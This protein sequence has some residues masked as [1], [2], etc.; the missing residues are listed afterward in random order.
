MESQLGSMRVTVGVTIRV[1]VKKSREG[2][3]Q[4]LRENIREG[5]KE[6]RS[7]EWIGEESECL[8]GSGREGVDD[9]RGEKR[10]REKGE[11]AGEGKDKAK[12]HIKASMM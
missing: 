4:W 10:V 6:G 8:E 7:E 9:M 1:V 3:A 5:V 12:K 11:G 2:W